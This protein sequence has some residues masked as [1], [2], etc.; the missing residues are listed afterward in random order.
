MAEKKLLKMFITFGLAAVLSCKGDQTPQAERDAASVEEKQTV[1]ADTLMVYQPYQKEGTTHYKAM[2]LSD[3]HSPSGRRQALMAIG[4][5]LSQT[6]F[7]AYG[8]RHTDISFSVDTIIKLCANTRCLHIG[9]I[10][11][12]DPDSVLFS[13]FFQGSTGGRATYNTLTASFLQPQMSPPLLDAVAFTIDGR[14]FPEMSHI[15]LSGI[16]VVRNLSPRMHR[17]LLQRNR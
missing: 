2:A 16:Q 1:V 3:H 5:Q 11:I 14:F 8:N 7:G 13:T 12:H 15:D 6:Y 10:S 4:K 9:L 17:E